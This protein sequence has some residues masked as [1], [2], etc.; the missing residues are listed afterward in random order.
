MA[1][2]VELGTHAFKASRLGG[3]CLVSRATATLMHGDNT[4]PTEPTYH[5]IDFQNAWITLKQELKVDLYIEAHSNPAMSIPS[6]VKQVVE[7]VQ[8]SLV[9]SSQEE[10]HQ[11]TDHYLPNRSMIT[12]IS[13]CRRYTT[14]IAVYLIQLLFTFP[15]SCAKY[16]ICR[17]NSSLE[18][19][20]AK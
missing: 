7:T 6:F 10:Y 14:N 3:Q 9:S 16:P 8:A 1:Q 18:G 15:S 19:C 4:S 5:C 13:D 17:L 2:L 11:M 12:R 20:L